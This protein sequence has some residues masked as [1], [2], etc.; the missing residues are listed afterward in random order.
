MD[1]ETVAT[2]LLKLKEQEREIEYTLQLVSGLANPKD[3]EAAFLFFQ[4][5]SKEYASRGE[6]VVKMRS[7]LDE[8]ENARKQS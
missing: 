7:I 5:R 8:I 1:T 2:L 6:D 4:H 3:P